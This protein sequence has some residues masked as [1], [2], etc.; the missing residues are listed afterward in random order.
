MQ[1]ELSYDRT[2]Q[3]TKPFIL[4]STIVIPVF[5]QASPCS[6]PQE[7]GLALR[8]EALPLESPRSFPGQLA[9]WTDKYDRHRN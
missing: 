8:S 9:F 7:V 6:P 5:P 1:L 4:I 2:K 3:I